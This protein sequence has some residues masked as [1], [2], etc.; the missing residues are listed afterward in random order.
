MRCGVSRN[1]CSPFLFLPPTTNAE[2]CAAIDA[3][4]ADA[5][6]LNSDQYRHILMAFRHKSYTNAPSLCLEMFDELRTI[7]LDAFTR[8]YDPYHDVSLNENLP[9]PVIELPALPTEGGLPFDSAEEVGT[10]DSGDGVNPTDRH[11]YFLVRVINRH[12]G[13]ETH[14]ST[15]GH[16]KAEK[17]AHLAECH[18]GVDL[19]RRPIRDAAGPVD[20]P[21]LKKVCH[22]AKMTR[23][24]EDSD[25]PDGHG[26]AFQPLE[27]FEKAV[28]VSEG[29]FGDR[30]TD[31]DRL[32]DLF[33]PMDTDRAEIVATLYAVWNDLLATGQQPTDELII[34]G[35][36]GW[37]DSKKKFERERLGKALAWMR[38]HGLTPTGK[39]KRSL[40]KDE[41]ASPAS[42]ARVTRKRKPKSQ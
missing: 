32:I 38:E 18:L 33:V 3:V 10:P 7:G 42:P 26:F 24:F 29:I 36:F 14:E 21:H 4:I 8:K 16:V 34:E 22:R 6:G 13:H 30:L 23:T 12:R 27:G 37:S 20:F 17:L 1:H 15:L 41:A 5:Y 31:M 11:R 28:T 2:T 25:R 39:G 35:F 9:Q 19:G 40:T